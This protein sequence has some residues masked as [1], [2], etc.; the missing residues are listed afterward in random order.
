MALPS[1]VCPHPS[2]RPA[3]VARARHRLENLPL[4]GP[5]VLACNHRSNLDP[6]F[7]GSACR[8]QVHFMAKAELWKFKR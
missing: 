3:P 2:A 8:R 4:T 1:C 6:F 7:L 5:V